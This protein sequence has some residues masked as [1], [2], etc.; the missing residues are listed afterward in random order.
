VID[1]LAKQDEDQE[2]TPTLEAIEL[3]ESTTARYHHD[4]ETER[5]KRWVRHQ[6]EHRR[7]QRDRALHPADSRG[8][9]VCGAAAAFH[10]GLAHGKLGSCAETG[11]LEYFERGI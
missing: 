4:I 3:A 10:R 5:R 11:C 1:A 9:C 8:K 6:E 7:R 2:V